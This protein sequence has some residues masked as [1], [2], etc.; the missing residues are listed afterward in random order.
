MSSQVEFYGGI[1]FP[2]R[3]NLCEYFLDHNLEQ[4]RGEKTALICGALKRTYR[5]LSQRAKQAAA[6]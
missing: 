5:E 3:F 6:C 1:G 4:G 2:E